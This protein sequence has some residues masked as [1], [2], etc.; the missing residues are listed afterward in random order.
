[1]ASGIAPGGSN[2][3]T[4]GSITKVSWKGDRQTNPR[5]VH[6]KVSDVSE[7]TVYEWKAKWAP[8]VDAHRASILERLVL[9]PAS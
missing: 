5:G 6:G 1:V 4:A 3:K 7:L 8:A 9:K 2:A